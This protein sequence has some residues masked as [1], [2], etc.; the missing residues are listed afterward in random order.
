MAG[1]FNTKGKREPPKPG[2][3]FIEMREGLCKRLLGTI[4]RIRFLAG[5][6]YLDVHVTQTPKEIL[7][8]VGEIETSEKS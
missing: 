1:I 3:S 5:D 2:V 7:G 8:R 4:E 6:G